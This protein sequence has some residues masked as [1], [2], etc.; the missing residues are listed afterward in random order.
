MYEGPSLDLTV[1]YTR[2]GRVYLKRSTRMHSLRDIKLY[3]SPLPKVR[4]SKA[5]IESSLK[6]GVSSL[7]TSLSYEQIRAAMPHTKEIAE[8]RLDIFDGSRLLTKSPKSFSTSD[9]A[10]NTFQIIY[11]P[12]LTSPHFLETPLD[13]SLFAFGTPKLPR[14]DESKRANRLP[15]LFGREKFSVS[16]KPERIGED[17]CIVVSAPFYQTLWLLPDKGFA[18]KKREYYVERS[19]V[20]EVECRDFREVSTGVWF[21]GEVVATEFGVKGHTPVQYE[22]VALMKT[23]F[24]LKKLDIN[25]QDT[26]RLFDFQ[27]PAGDWIADETAVDESRRGKVE[28]TSDGRRKRPIVSYAMPADVRELDR[29]ISNA[30]DPASPKAARRN[31]AWP[32]AMMNLAL[33]VSVIVWLTRFRRR[34]PAAGSLDKA[35]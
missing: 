34:G 35:T 32:I 6:S 9:K 13:Y 5:E 25:D 15:E 18:V 2:D 12:R 26:E 23:R 16:P 7:P 31:L 29:V 14:D 21:P 10:F 3:I 1:A 4:P 33:I 11:I 28:T 30:K 17:L 19:K 22:G 8:E 27:P 20:M 24:N